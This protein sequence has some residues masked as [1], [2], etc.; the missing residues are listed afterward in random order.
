MDISIKHSELKAFSANLNNWAQQMRGVR[1]EIMART[2]QLESH[3]KDPQYRMFV[4][5]AQ[6][7]GKNLVNAIEQFDKMSKQLALLANDME[8]AQQSARARLRNSL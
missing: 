1:N 6:S 2:H 8:R 3:W 4:D 5:M 7:H